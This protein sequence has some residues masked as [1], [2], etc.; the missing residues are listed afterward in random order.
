MKNKICKE[1]GNS[2]KRCNKC[3]QFLS[4][5]IF[6]VLILTTLLLSTISALSCDKTS[7]TKSVNVGSTPSSEAITCTNPNSYNVTL[8]KSGDFFST[9][10]ITNFVIPNDSSQSFVV[11][12]VQMNSG[13]SFIGSLLSTDGTTIPI[14]VNVSQLSLPSSCSIDIFPTILGNVKVQQGEK[15][16]RTIQIN[17]P[18]CYSSY[19]DFNGVILA[20]DEKPILLGE[21]SLGRKNPGESIMI[22]LDIDATGVSTGTYQDSLSISAYNSSGY[23]VNL[24]SVSISVLVSSGIN[25]LTNFSFSQLPT[26]SLSSIILNMNGTY[27]LTCTKN[28]PNIMINP[29]IDNN[30]I[31]GVSVDETP[32]QYVYNFKAKQVG[33]TSISAKFKYSN[34]EVGEPFYQEVK[35]TP[36]GTSSVGGV[37]LDLQFF[38]QGVEKLKSNLNM[39]ETILVVLDNSSR[40]VVSSFNV[41]LNGE[42]VSSNKINLE[43]NKNYNLRIVS[44]SYND[45][46]INNLSV[47]QLPLTITLEPSL[48]SYFVGDIVNLTSNVENVTFLFDNTIVTSPYTL[49]SQGEHTLQAV[50]EGYI[51][52]SMNVSVKPSIYFSAVTP[53]DLSKWKVGDSVSMTLTEDA[54]WSVLFNDT[55]ISSGTGKDVTFKIENYGT[56]EVMANE[57]SVISASIVR[58]TQVWDWIKKYWYVPV[59]SVVGLVIL[60]FVILAIKGGSE[61][62]GGV[63]LGGGFGS[64]VKYN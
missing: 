10:P 61:S 46:L 59:A 32:T 47:G 35:I 44:Q 43:L 40:N 53:N 25:P 26:C 13:G 42:N 41:I 8:L 19:I 36:S 9:L 15:K 18:P 6:L 27:Q 54:S 62:A 64:S 39:G 3:R 31:L 58:N 30:Y 23:N 22:P 48:D 49:V 33:I 17:V 2:K 28:N 38:Q 20:T 56:Y 63:P 14:S 4:N 5:K 21:L 55:I 52:Y 1:K 16:S 24:P 29:V 50:K 34:A 60:I 51:S 45:L 7:I 11:N 57:K 37:A 12:F